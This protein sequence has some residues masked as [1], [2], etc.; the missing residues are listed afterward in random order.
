MRTHISV[1]AW[2]QEPAHILET[3]VELMLL[4]IEDEEEQ[5]KEAGKRG[6]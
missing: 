4:Q 2:M 5:S 1:S 6:G 3:A